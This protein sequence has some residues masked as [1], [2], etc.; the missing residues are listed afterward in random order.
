MRFGHSVVAGLGALLLLRSC[1]PALGFTQAPLTLPRSKGAIQLSNTSE[2]SIELSLQV[3]AV[4]HQGGKPSAALAP[5]PVEQ[6]EQVIRLR[7]TQMR[8]AS[9]S[10][11]TI[12]YTVFDPSRDFFLCG[13]SAQ[14]L[15][16][17]RVCSRW[18]PAFAVS[19]SAP[20][21]QR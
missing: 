15:F 9:G 12:P 16:M 2:R 14:G 19:S 6:A 10:T 8:L 18:R 21:G 3:F 1:L 5:L 4:V 13:V 17:L 7:P 11:R 20:A